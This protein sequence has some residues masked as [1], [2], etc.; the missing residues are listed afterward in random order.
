[1][2]DMLNDGN[3]RVTYVASIANKAAPTVA[4]LDAGVDLECLVTSDGLNTPVNEDTVSN[5]KLC[6]TVNAEAPGRATH[7]PALT[8]YRQDTPSEDV[9]WT[10]M[11]RGTAGFLVVRYGVAHDTAYAAGDEVCVYPGKAG[12]R[13]LQTPEANAATKFISRWY[14]SESPVLD[15][16]VAA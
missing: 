3:I 2:A 16:E 15:A 7:Q 13:Q 1:M 8:F 4:E 14:E 10:T 9:A 6:D 5:P 12:E 11:T